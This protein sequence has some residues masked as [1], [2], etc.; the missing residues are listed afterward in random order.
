[1]HPSLKEL[2]WG[3]GN[4]GEG[5]FSVPSVSVSARRASLLSMAV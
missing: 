2:V 4:L 1:M 5:K 3:T